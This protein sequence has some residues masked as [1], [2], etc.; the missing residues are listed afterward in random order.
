MRGGCD[1]WQN[2]EDDPRDDY[3][4]TEEGRVHPSSLS[5][6]DQAD[7]WEPGELLLRS[8]PRLEDHI[9]GIVLS[10][11]QATGCGFANEIGALSRALATW[12]ADLPASERN[13]HSAPFGL[14]E[15]SLDAAH[16]F[17]SWAARS[18]TVDALRSR[19]LVVG[20]TLALFHDVGKLRDLEVAEPV[21]GELWEPLC[22]PVTHFRASH[23][24]PQWGRRDFDWLP[25]RGAHTHDQDAFKLVDTILPPDFTPA[26]RRDLRSGMEAIGCCSPKGLE[27]YPWPLPYL[28]VAVRH[29]DRESASFRE[30]SR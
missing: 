17:I 3:D 5:G 28:S 11:S 18:Q 29:A 16:R 22:E 23:Q 30:V 4:I 6:S 20:V 27:D 9:D 19:W 14:L 21:H 8:Q 24:L 13:H 10:L 26:F 1:G 25:G 15:H 7:F 12:V 2:E